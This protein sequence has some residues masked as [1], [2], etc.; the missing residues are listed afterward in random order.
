MKLDYSKISMRDLCDMAD[1]LDSK[2]YDR[3]C[4]KDAENENIARMELIELIKGCS[5]EVS[6]DEN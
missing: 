4:Q 1:E 6:S 2:E 3:L 5:W